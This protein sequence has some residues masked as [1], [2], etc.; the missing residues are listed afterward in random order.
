MAEI[1]N[2]TNRGRRLSGENVI[3]PED[4]SVSKERCL[5]PINRALEENHYTTS[6]NENFQNEI[7]QTNSSINTQIYM[8]GKNGNT[9][10]GNAGPILNG[11]TP[12]IQGQI[13]VDRFQA[14][15]AIVNITLLINTLQD[16]RE[17]LLDESPSQHSDNEKGCPHMDPKKYYYNVVVLVISISLQFVILGIACSIAVSELSRDN[18]LGLPPSKEDIE[19]TKRNNKRLFCLHVIA[20]LVT[21]VS[22]VY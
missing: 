22:S 12:H 21:I 14:N 3:E 10:F 4:G 2:I 6:V 13:T 15:A 18:I 9:S 7:T 19:R 11:I 5:M 20:L 1:K 16:L 8:N 17:I